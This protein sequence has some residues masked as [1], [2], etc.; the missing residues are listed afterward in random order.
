M[1]SEISPV[2]PDFA[3]ESSG[4]D[5]GGLGIPIMAVSV[6]GECAGCREA[7]WVGGIL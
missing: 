4:V 2:V 3:P 7:L 6:V 1:K 5:P